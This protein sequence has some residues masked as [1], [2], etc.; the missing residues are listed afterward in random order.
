MIHWTS[1]TGICINLHSNF[2]S[3]GTPCHVSL[4]LTSYVKA[5][6]LIDRIDIKKEMCLQQF[7]SCPCAPLTCCRPMVFVSLDLFHKFWPVAK[8]FQSACVL[9]HSYP[10]LLGV[11]ITQYSSC[12]TVKPN[13]RKPLESLFQHRWSGIWWHTLISYSALSHRIGHPVK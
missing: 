1:K 8:L 5:H 7:L 6:L 9:Q 4:I 12:V 10:G 3:V 2:Y 11:W 13:L